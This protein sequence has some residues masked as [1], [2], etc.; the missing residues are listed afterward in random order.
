M[1]DPKRMAELILT[2]TPA[3]KTEFL[4]ALAHETDDFLEQ[5]GELRASGDVDDETAAIV[6]AGMLRLQDL[7][8]V[9]FNA[10]TPDVI[11]AEVKEITDRMTMVVL[12]MELRR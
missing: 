11:A 9:A 2:M 6:Y 10:G 3:E 4:V 8:V 1:I 7:S 12:A 5:L